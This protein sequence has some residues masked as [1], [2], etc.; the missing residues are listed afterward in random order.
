MRERTGLAQAITRDAITVV[1][2]SD[3]ARAAPDSLSALRVDSTLA[4][5]RQST[6]AYAQAID[7]T[8]SRNNRWDASRGW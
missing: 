2:E 5:L 6:T 8:L 7:F 1:R 3:R 4:A